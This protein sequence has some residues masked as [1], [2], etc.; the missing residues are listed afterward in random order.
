M[1]GASLGSVV[2]FI[3][4]FA[5]Y[6]R[7]PASSP[8]IQGVEGL[9]PGN[10]MMM[11]ESLPAAPPDQ[12]ANIYAE[13]VVDGLPPINPTYAFATHAQDMLNSLPSAMYDSAETVPQYEAMANY[14]ETGMYDAAGP[15]RQ[16][17]NTVHIQ[18]LGAV[19]PVYEIPVCVD[20]SAIEA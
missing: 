5:L 2:I 3:I 16:R 4:L 6:R 11:M 8:S 7:K 15:V 1:I 18:P 19:G 12:Y 9:Q 14:S 13:T 20:T 10:I 17:S